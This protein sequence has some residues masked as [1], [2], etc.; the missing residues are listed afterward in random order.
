M[1]PENCVALTAGGAMRAEDDRRVRQKS[2]YPLRR[3]FVPHL[4]DILEKS[5]RN[6]S[7]PLEQPIGD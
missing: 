2:A 7:G 6:D 5:Q 1:R 3:G 4:G